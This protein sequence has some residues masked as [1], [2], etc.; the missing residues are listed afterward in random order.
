MMS[1]YSKFCSLLVSNCRCVHKVRSSLRSLTSLISLIS[2]SQ[3]KGEYW[4][5]F[6]IRFRMYFRIRFLMN[7]LILFLALT[8]IDLVR[9]FLIL[10]FLLLFSLTCINRSN[11]NEIILIHFFPYYFSIEVLQT[12]SPSRCTNRQAELA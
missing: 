10:L 1:Y 4:R 7:F 6:R 5:Y 12:H 3:L 2:S 8:V 9:F 11:S